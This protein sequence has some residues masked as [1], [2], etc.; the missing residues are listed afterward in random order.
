MTLKRRVRHW[1]NV[2][3]TYCTVTIVVTCWPLLA[4]AGDARG[5]VVLDE[6]QATRLADLALHCVGTEYPNKL[7]HVLQD[8]TDA[9]TPVQLHPAF[10]GCF[11]WHSAVHGHWMLVRIL[12]LYPE[13]AS[14]ERIR[15]ALDENLQAQKIRAEVE[16]LEGE[17]R[18]SFERTYGWAWLLKL[19][20]ELHAWADDD[21]RRW[22][23]NLQPLADEIVRRYI[24]FLPRQY[25]PIRRGVHA[26]SAFGIAF[27]LDYARATGNAELET[28]L[29]ER[30]T[31]YYASDTDCPGEWEPDGDDFL[32]PCLQEADLMRRVLPG[33]E[34]SQWFATFLPALA[35]GDDS[36]L[37]TPAVVT[38]RSDP[39]LVHL[40]GLN[41]SRAWCLY[42]IAAALSNSDLRAQLNL[43]ADVHLR[44]TLEFISSGN[45][46]G[47]HW[48][49][50]FA[51]YALPQSR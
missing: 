5:R 3:A 21:A 49:A 15:R 47:E 22:S 11:D 36:P 17:G 39:K 38:D 26:N 40:D 29:V 14:A 4:A 30:A 41:L 51:V 23:G 27:A 44:A 2:G 37:L 31:A 33:D 13:L 34:F 28:V 7:S 12:K 42:G 10:F 1:A 20:E 25:Y 48:L 6:Q 18:A 24:D 8:K 45:Y 43:A 16:Y 9:R 35:R 50:S 32:S 19:R 46:A